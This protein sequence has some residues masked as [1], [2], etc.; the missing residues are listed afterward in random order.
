MSNGQQNGVQTVIPVKS[1]LLV[2][3]VSMTQAQV[4]AALQAILTYFSAVRNAKTSLTAAFQAKKAQLVASHALYGQL[5]TALESQF[6][7]E[8]P[9]LVKFGLKPKTPARQLTSAQKA[10][11][12][13]KAKVTRELRH[14]MGARAKET[15]VASDP[16]VTVDRTGVQ[17]T[18]APV[19]APAETGVKGSGSPSGTPTTQK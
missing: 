15:V 2:K 13:G 6:G 1:T 11:R 19:D 4:V 9:E 16:T 17:V 12:A 5:R 7:K 10:L 3:G 14:T 8:N 18:P